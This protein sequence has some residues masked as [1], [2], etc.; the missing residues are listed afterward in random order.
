ML[1]EPLFHPA[2]GLTDAFRLRVVAYSYLHGAVAAAAVFNV[3]R[4]SIYRW[5]DAYKGDAL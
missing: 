2:Y 4:C 5:R 3:A 1:T